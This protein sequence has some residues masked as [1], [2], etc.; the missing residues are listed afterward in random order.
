MRLRIKYLL[1]DSQTTKLPS[2]L[3]ILLTTYIAN[4]N[5]GDSFSP[6]S[7][8]S[9]S[10]TSPYATTDNAFKNSASQT[11]TGQCTWYVY[12]RVMELVAKGELEPSEG[13][14]FHDA[15]WGTWNRH[16]KNWKNDNFLG[17]TW[18]CTN[19][20]TLPMAYRRKGLIAVWTN[21]P[22]GH[23]GFVEEVNADKTLYRL[24]D[25]NRGDD[26]EYRNKWYPFLGT[27]DQLG[28]QYPCFQ[29]LNLANTANTPSTDQPISENF[30][31]K[32][33]P[34]EWY[35]GC[36]TTA[37]S[38]LLDW[39]GDHGY[40]KLYGEPDY[41]YKSGCETAYIRQDIA[42]LYA[43]NA[44]S[45][46]LTCSKGEYGASPDEIVAGITHVL[47]NQGYCVNEDKA[48][49]W[50]IVNHFNL[51]VQD[52]VN[53][54]NHGFPLS[55]GVDSN[56]FQNHFDFENDFKRTINHR[57]VAY[58]YRTY[59]Q[60]RIEISLLTGWDTDWE[61]ATRT[62]IINGDGNT[63]IK[64]RGLYVKPPYHPDA[65]IITRATAVKRIFERFNIPQDFG[66]DSGFDSA[67][68]SDVSRNTTH[69]QYIA[70]AYNKGIVHGFAAGDMRGKYGPFY[71]VSRVEFIKMVM[72]TLN[73]YFG[74]PL[75]ASNFAEPVNVFGERFPDMDYSAWYYKFVKAAY[76]YGIIQGTQQGNLM[77]HV[78]LSEN[79]GTWI[80]ERAE[81]QL[82]STSPVSSD[83]IWQGNGSLISYHGRLLPNNAG[84]DWPYGITQDVVQLHAS[85]QKPVG[86]FQWQV[87]ENGCKRLKLEADLPTGQNQVDITIG[88][89]NN[90]DDDITFSQVKLPFVLGASNTDYRFDMENGKWYVVKVALRQPLNQAV[91]LNAECTTTTPTDL[92][93]RRGGGEAR[94]LDGGY[95]WNGNA[96]IIS[97]MFRNLWYK[98]E[99]SRD[100]DWPYGAFKD[101]LKVRRSSE[102]PMIFFQWQRDS[103]CSRLTFDAELS[104]TEKRVDIHV[105]NWSASND[106]ATVHRSV[107]LPY[108]ISDYSKEG[109]WRVIQIKFLKPVSYTANVTAKCAGID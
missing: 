21:S 35:R 100:I 94:V 6:T 9:T 108:T 39:F 96:S 2:L 54:I 34:M 11:L 22:N 25:F 44:T 101:T 89:W 7:I 87:N 78:K 85:T 68:P 91:E 30:V 60:D 50:Q 57:V 76:N 58:G 98:S 46:P 79:E 41:A 23:V 26:T 15:F 13:T 77:P 69:Y 83:Y 3:I 43:D 84:E 62:I 74:V 105:K 24:T 109:S 72:N 71:S 90:R 4:V 66:L 106:A 36:T 28:G 88:P 65:R 93:Y 32:P 53:T 33:T 37:V 64:E 73:L 55:L 5:A 56:T 47:E 70:T 20:D 38:M 86:F 59:E 104:A 75:E 61:N 31:D 19:N 8:I 17:G 1:K 27:E 103:V 52:L 95:K 51:T 42:D 45:S 92:R 18:H 49:C 63:E 81:K 14:R 82:S 16:A 10:S 29:T 107:T 80:L 12:G 97:H 40:N 99:N 102:K 48:A 67:Q